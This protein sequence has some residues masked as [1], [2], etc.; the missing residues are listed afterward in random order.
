MYKQYTHVHTY[1]NDKVMMQ[2]HNFKPPRESCV[3]NLDIFHEN[4]I[5]IKSF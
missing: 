2:V 1:N 3:E 4:R 5:K